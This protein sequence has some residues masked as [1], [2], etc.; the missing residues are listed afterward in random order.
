M[1]RMR[2]LAVAGLV[3]GVCG[4]CR[5]KAP[6]MPAVWSAET[7]AIVGGL[8][9]PECALYDEA[10]DR[11]LVSN[12]ET[13][14]KGYWE[15]DRKGFVTMMNRDGVIVKKRWLDSSDETPL[16]APK[17]MGILGGYLYAADI[18]SLKRCRIE[19][20]AVIETVEL[21]EAE[22]LNDIACDGKAIWVSDIQL[23]KVYRVDS[24]GKVTEIPAPEN[25]N[26]VACHDGKVFAVSWYHHDIYELD[27]AGAE[28][29][30][31]FGLAGHFTNLD[32]IEILDDGTFVVSDFTGGKVC[33]VG[34]DRKTVRT[35]VELETPAD[36][37][38]DRKRGLLYVPQLTIDKLVILKLTQQ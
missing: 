38:L 25:V 32:G 14:T 34:A 2:L 12:I 17:G 7:A 11:V 19:M 20:P 15:S 8:G 28:K 5:R 37:G 6:A 26:G 23:S 29:P 4:G 21:P 36:I 22:K 13:D 33:T 27:P 18:D 31:A 9:A 30:V 16:D 1:E 3:I 10:A 24:E 35:L